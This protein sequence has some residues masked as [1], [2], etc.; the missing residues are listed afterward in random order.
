MWECKTNYQVLWETREEAVKPH[1]TKRHGMVTYK[2]LSYCR[3]EPW[4]CK[5]STIAGKEEEYKD[6]AK[7]L[8]RTGT[9]G[10]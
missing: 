3:L 7:T 8:G 2:T 4:R 5:R 6:G 9:D 10:K 1:G